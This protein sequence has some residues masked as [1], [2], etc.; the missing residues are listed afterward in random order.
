VFKKEWTPEGL[1][2]CVAVN[3]A[4]AVDTALA[5]GPHLAP[6]ALVVFVSSGAAWRWRCGG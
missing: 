1:A 3:F 6:G 5:L 2:E 4:G